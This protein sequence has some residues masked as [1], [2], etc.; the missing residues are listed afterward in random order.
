MEIELKSIDIS[1]IIPVFNAEDYVEGCIESVRKQTLHNM[2]I[3]CIDD[4]SK[5]NTLYKL[6]E[7]QKKDDRI[8]IFSQKNSGAGAARNI[9]LSNARGKFI[10][11]L[12][13]DDYFYDANALEL[14]YNACIKNQVD[15][16]GSYR[17]KEINGHLEIEDMFQT[18]MIDSKVGSCIEYKDYQNDFH[19]QS[20]IFSRKLLEKNNIYF[21]QYLRYQDPPFFLKAMISAGKFWV[22]PT[23]LYCYR[24]GHQN[25]EANGRKIKYT[26][27][28]IKDN[29]VMASEHGFDELFRLLINRLNSTY[30]KYILSNLSDEVMELLL[31]IQKINIQY[32]NSNR[33]YLLEDIYRFSSGYSNLNESY[34]MMRDLLKISQNNEILKKYFQKQGIKK[35][36]VYGLGTFGKIFVDEVLR[37]EVEVVVA[38]DKSAEAYKGIKVIRPENTVPDCDA[39]IVSP[40][41]TDDI[42]ACLENKKIKK[43]FTLKN[44]VKEMNN[45]NK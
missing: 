8:I 20:Y 41:K 4:G 22:M 26:L 9:G 35:I 15:I 45:S 3:I 32:G 42:I 2:E 37:T 38:I 30:Y 29:L 36:V 43:I 1:V 14:M 19:Y 27:L 11:F 21:P 6:K 12:D 17:Y 5:D 28:G 25:E 44:M 7:L 33:F 10:A 39:V 40:L 13:V 18:F 24:Y 31:Q 23:F 16:C 34:M